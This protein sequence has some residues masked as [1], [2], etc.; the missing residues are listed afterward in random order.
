MLLASSAHAADCNRNGMDDSIDISTGVSNDCQPDGIPDECQVEQLDLSYRHDNGFGAQIGGVGT[1]N[2]PTQVIAWLAHHVVEPDRTVV[3]GFQIVW[4]LLPVGYPATVAIWSDPNGDGDPADASIIASVETVV[5][6][7]WVPATVVDIAFPETDLGAP[8]TSFF[9]GAWVEGV[10]DFPAGIPAT[11]D[12]LATAGESWW[13]VSYPPFDPDNLA[14]GA[15]EYGRIGDLIPGFRGDWY[16]RLTYCGGGHCG[17]SPDL[18]SNGIPDECDE[19][20]NRN[21]LPDGYDIAQGTATDCNASGVPDSCESLSDCDDNGVADLCQNGPTGLVGQYYRNMNLAGAAVSRIDA[22]VDFTFEGA[23]EVPPTFPTDDFSVRWTGTLIAPVAGVYGIGLRH[24]DGVRLW[25]DGRLE[26]DRWEGSAGSLDIVDRTFAAGERVHVR[27]E[28]F[29][30]SGLALCDF[31]WRLPGATDPVTVPTSTLRPI[32]DRDAN[33]IPDLCADDDCNA[34]FIADRTDLAIGASTDCDGNGELDDCQTTGDCDG[35][36]QIDACQA[37]SSG[38]LTGE[39]FF[40]YNPVTGAEQPGRTT[41]LAGSRIDP[42]INFDWNGI[43]PG[44]GDLTGDYYTVRWRGTLT[45]P[46]VAGLYTFVVGRDDGARLWIGEQLIIDAWVD[47]STTAQASIAL[48]ASTTY[49]IRLEVYNGIGG[50]RAVL[51]WIPP[52]GSYGIVPTAVLRP[53]DD[54]DGNGTPDGCDVD[55]DGDGIADDLAIASGLDADCN[56]NGVPDSCDVS[57][58]PAE[59]ETLG[60]W[61]FEPSATLGEDS[62]PNGLDAVVNGAAAT[63][64]VPVSQIPLTG[65]ANAG[66]VATGAAQS[67][68]VADPTGILML[69]AQPFTVESWV[70]IDQLG[71]P[72][73]AGRQW[74]FARKPAL[75]SD[76]MLDWGF[77]AQAGDFGLTTNVNHRFGKTDGYSGRELAFVFGFGSG[78]ALVQKAVLVTTLE[79][80]ASGWH[81]VS[82]AFDPSRRIGRF[83]LDGAS[84]EI[85]VDRLWIVGDPA[86][87]LTMG[88]HPTGTGLDGFLRGA[89]DEARITW[90]VRPLN[91]LLKSPY[92]P[93]SEDGDANGVPDEC[94]SACAADIT[95]DGSV[96]AADLSQMLAGWGGRKSDIDGDGTGGA[97]DL[98]LLLAAWGVCR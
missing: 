30:A 73:A 44:V 22:N 12:P 84:E 27:I 57:T 9:I 92:A 36:L 4:G 15:L 86:Q 65:A 81:H 62:G 56:R 60:Y 41:E 33:G 47:G 1:N 39:Y 80:A 82:F 8:G 35:D 6:S 70:R 50:G 24:D 3:N 46:V 55:C 78:T 93:V 87:P 58:T 16:L 26:I 14:A 25:I 23:P 61:R 75:N 7:P 45:T 53:I 91:R 76:A 97:S 98:S 17:E 34:N 5:V 49:R 51:G 83:T 96:D 64:S 85:I 11:Y 54:V 29:E 66:A 43:T 63:T 52:G 89:I 59:P 19:D 28:Y 20:C 42:T 2:G 38:G 88:A 18:D 37:Q 68:S 94:A 10:A 67:L 21:G 32:D 74:L 69:G 90:G 48:A 79:V 40:S 77:L 95:G 71:T 13:I 31:V 72:N